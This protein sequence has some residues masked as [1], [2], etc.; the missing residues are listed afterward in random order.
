MKIAFNARLLSD[1]SLRGWNRYTVNL[2]RGLAELGVDPVLFCISPVHESHLEKI[3]IPVKVIAS[4]PM[5]VMRWEQRWFPRAAIGEKADLIH[6]TTNFGLPVLPCKLPRVLTMHDAIDKLYSRPNLSLRQCLSMGAIQCEAMIYSS[7]KV[8]DRVIT[9][10]EHAKQDIAK[11]YRIPLSRIRVTYEAAD[12]VFHDNKGLLKDEGENKVDSRQPY[13]FYVGGWEGRKNVP[14]LVEAF[15]KVKSKTSRLVLAGGSE[16]QK[17]EIDGLAQ[18]LGVQDRVLLL[19]KITDQE[20]ADYYRGALAFVYPSAYEG[21]GLQLCEA[22]V[23]GTPIL[24]SDRTSLPEILGDGGE[25][26]SLASDDEL[27][28]LMNRV[29][30]DPE[31]QR[32]LQ[33]RSSMRGRDY[34]WAQCAE[35]TK[36]VYHELIDGKFK[37]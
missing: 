11:A 22:M 23:F 14:F 34:S 24:S 31:F 33:T 4:G 3:G 32:S 8:A 6:A 17:R 5:R 10:S 37:K 29:L 28:A 27:V 35:S 2:I 13:F 20:L 36:H 25:I 15:S 16:S 19:G 9:V 21:F 7:L 12:P 18:R 1:P 26:F 30:L